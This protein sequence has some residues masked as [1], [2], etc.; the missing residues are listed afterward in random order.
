M[1]ELWQLVALGLVPVVLLFVVYRR[2]RARSAAGTATVSPIEGGYARDE[3]NPLAGQQLEM[4]QLEE[5]HQFVSKSEKSQFLDKPSHFRVTL[6]KGSKHEV[7]DEIDQF[8][9]PSKAS[10]RKSDSSKLT[11][12]AAAAAVEGALLDLNPPSKPSEVSSGAG[13]QEEEEEL[14]FDEDEYDE[15]TPA[16][17]EFAVKEH[18]PEVPEVAAPVVEEEE[19]P[20]EVEYEPAE[21][22][23]PAAVVVE[24]EAAADPVVEEE[25]P[26]ATQPE[27]EQAVPEPAEVEVVP[28]E[29]Q[30]VPEQEEEQVAEE[31]AA[32][33]EEAAQPEE[34]QAAQPEEE[35]AQPED[36]QLLDFADHAP[37]TSNSASLPDFSTTEMFVP[38]ASEGSDETHLLDFSPKPAATTT[39]ATLDGD[40]GQLIDFSDPA[41]TKAADLQAEPAPKPKSKKKKASK[42]VN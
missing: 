14:V 20:F 3:D 35:Q 31:Q 5:G 16:V 34:E 1:A 4:E 33:Q 13:R 9:A 26:V 39:A 22:E 38:P 19:A 36:E 27:E 18:V 8:L 23:Q 37:A 28:A 24:E 21:V 30:A 2:C 29:E 41:P 25:E 11:P 10:K 32:E 6:P 17:V 12:A 40:D 42:P 7:E 15:I